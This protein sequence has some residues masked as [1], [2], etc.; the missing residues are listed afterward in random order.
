MDSYICKI[1]DF[2]G[3]KLNLLF[4]SPNFQSFGDSVEQIYFSLLHCQSKN[5]K[6]ILIKP[7]NKFFFK[8]VSISNKY[9]YQLEHELIY[10][11]PFL[12]EIFFS[13]L[14]TLMAG[15]SFMNIKLRKLIATIFKLEKNF[16]HNINLT[17]RSRQHFGKKYLYNYYEKVNFTLKDWQELE[18][19]YKSP[20]L[21]KVLIKD[22]EDFINFHAPESLNKKW[23]VLH[24]LDNTKIN[25]ARGADIKNYGLAIDHLIEN[26]FHVFRLGDSSMPACK[27]EGLTDLANIKHE[28]FID[29]YLI[30]SAF[31][32]IA[33]QSGPAYATNLFDTNLLATNL[34]DW[35]TAV[36]RKKGNFFINKAFYNK[37]DNTRFSVSN[38]LEQD[39]NFQIN[40]DNIDDL[41]ISLEENSK[42]EIL[43]ALRD[44]LSFYNS[45][46]IYTDLQTDYVKKREKW[47]DKNLKENKDLKIHYS[48]DSVYDYQRIRSIALSS[49]YGTV[50]NSFLK[51]YW[52]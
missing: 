16:H 37:S 28:S 41:D 36:T 42:S 24:V 11:L 30:N 12:I 22:S 35:S 34:T 51:K 48:P 33:N 49:T 27:K 29:L 46:S 39:F 14:L 40:V 31:L 8:E 23:V 15:L 25:F 17:W 43:E 21:P 5:K 3:E 10:K 38:L 45:N 50:A 26:N 7:F 32:M 6:L 47:L 20:E 52:N 13:C 19:N 1:V 44:Y 9:L 4:L 2:L 18:S